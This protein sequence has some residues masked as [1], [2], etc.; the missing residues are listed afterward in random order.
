MQVTP[1][2]GLPEVAPGDDLAGLIA[3]AAD[4]ADGDVCCVA[5]TVVSK[6]AGRSAAQLP[7]TRPG[8]G[9]PSRSV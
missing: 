8:S 4:P 7:A 6:A 3:E 9:V 1:V 2:T 5:S